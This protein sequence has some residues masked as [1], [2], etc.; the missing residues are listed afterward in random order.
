MRRRHIY[1]LIITAVTISALATVL[2]GIC[3]ANRRTKSVPL[4]PAVSGSLI[5]GLA[6]GASGWGGSSTET[7]LNEL[8][9]TGSKWMRDTFYWSEIEPSPGRFDWSYYDHYMLLVGKKGLHIVAQL[10]GAPSWA[11]PTSTSVPANPA[12][13]AKF[14]AEVAHRYGPDGTFWRR[15]PSLS[16][17]AID[18]Y[19][20]W[21][22]PYYSSGDGG[23]YDPGRY[24]RLVKAASIAT[25]A[26]APSAKILLEA[27]M[28]PNLTNGV[29]VWWTDALYRAMPNLNR[30]FDGVAVH[31]YGPYM[32]S[33]SPIVYGQPYPNFQHIRRIEDLHRQFLHHGAASKPFWIM[34][35]GWATCNQDNIDCVTPAAQKTN[36][37]TLF[38]YLN[39]T[40]KTWVQAAFLYTYQDGSQ[41]DTVQGGYGLVYDNGQPKPALS[42]FKQ[43]AA[44]SAG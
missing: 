15:Y 4:R 29:W 34:E 12:S 3:G 40:W 7:R 9:S 6:Q 5:V 25:H 38:G 30:Y 20:I 43:Y 17:S 32:K 11:A 41:P 35:T 39:T 2:V 44:A 37:A 21:N 23:D 10:V 1:P 36:L 22:E 26:V 31:D 28:Q 18:E 42:L 13:F 14:V 33:L 19:E 16:G 24:A 27:E 8:T